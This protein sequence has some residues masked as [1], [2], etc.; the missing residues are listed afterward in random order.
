MSDLI[1]KGGTVIDGTGAPAVRADVSVDGGRICQ[2]GQSLGGDRTLDA[3]GCVV[4]PGFI[5][6]H[7]HYDAQVF[8][9]PHLTPSCFHGVTTVV[10]GNCGFSIAPTRPEHRDLIARTLQKVEDMDV[11]T[12]R[13]GIPWDFVSFPEYLASVGRRGL[14]L[15]FMAYV[16]HTAV[17]IFVMG[18]EASERPADQDELAAMKTVVRQAMEA[19]AAGFATSFASTHLGADGRPIPSRVATREEVV[20]L[21]EVLRDAGRGVAAFTGGDLI[22]MKDLYD[23][24]LTIGQPFT[25]AAI[26]SSPSGRHLEMLE[27]NAAGWARGAQVWPQVSP[28]PLRFSISMT[29]PFPLNVNSNFAALMK[30]DIETRRRTYA[31]TEFRARCVA[32]WER[33]QSMTPRWE[34]YA[35]AESRHPELL[36][37]MLTDVARD[38]GQ[39][40][41]ET[42]MDLA[43]DEPNLRVEAMLANDDP[44][45]VAHI[46]VQEHCTLGLSD[47]G[48]HVGQLCDAPQA[49]DYLGNWVR[50]KGL[51]PIEEGVR[52]LTSQQADIIG[53]TDR[54]RLVPGNCADVVVFDPE[55]VSPG[56]IRRVRD[57][58][59]DSERLTA[60]RPV[61]IRHVLVNGF[62]IQVD[63]EP[64]HSSRPGQVLRPA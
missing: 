18:E 13:A 62:P 27:D 25:V 6:I 40:A 24:Q 5:D 23:L 46:L 35:I 33:G 47:A 61:G 39:G 34:T 11:D 30:E 9:D 3:S 17:R 48:A 1:I 4:A 19:G 56:P 38:R 45:A 8:W 55:T 37:R 64:D 36:G 28:R 41:F 22:P 43:A 10:A 42:L 51:L 53:L 26:L 32:E 44:D 60:D 7:T 16:G 52:R 14:G 49:T 29:E 20:A 31:D 21:L 50:E 59:A 15:N 63:G 58:P 57:F 2:I 12:L 54:G